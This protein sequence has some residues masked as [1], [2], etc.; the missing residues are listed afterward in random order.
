M[1]F[2]KKRFRDN[3][4]RIH[5]KSGMLY[6]EAAAN[7]GIHVNTYQGWASGKQMPTSEGLYRLSIAY[8]VPMEDFMEGCLD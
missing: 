7:A 3:L 5:G 6:K 2:N 8:G 4:L 1:K